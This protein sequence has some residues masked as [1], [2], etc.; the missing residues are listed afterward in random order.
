MTHF[1]NLLFLVG[2]VS[3][4]SSTFATSPDEAYR[5]GW[6]LLATKIMKQPFLF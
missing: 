6:K 1:F 4:S 2:L 3:F 5:L